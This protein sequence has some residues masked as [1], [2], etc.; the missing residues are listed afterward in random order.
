M[1]EGAVAPDA[2]RI[3]LF[4]QGNIGQLIVEPSSELGFKPMTHEHARRGASLSVEDR[5]RM[6]GAH[7]DCV[8]AV[9]L[10]CNLPVPSGALR[11]H[12]NCPEGRVLDVDFQLFDG[13]DQHVAAV[14]LTPKYGRE[15]ADH[16][17]SPDRASLMEP[18]TVAS[19]AHFAV[20]AVFRLPL[21]D[22]RQAALVDRLLQVGQ[23]DALQFQR[24]LALGHDSS[25]LR[26]ARDDNRASMQHQQRTAIVTGAGKRIGAVIAA[27][28]VADG[29][30]VVAHVHHAEDSVPEGAAKVVAELTDLECAP[31]IFDAAEALPPVRLLVNNAA[32]FAPDSFGEFREAEL[33][34]HM[35]V[36]L[37][38][39]I[40]LSE[41]FSRRHSGDDGLIVNLLD[42]KLAAPNPDFLSYTLSKQALA[43][44][45]DL[46]SR[47][48]ASRGIR[49]NAIA[50]AL[51]LRSSGQSVE[52]F[53]RVHSL[54]PLHRGVEPEDVVSALRYLIS[55]RAVTGETIVIDGGQ[56]FSPPPRDVQFLED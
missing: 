39:P 9:Q 18:G 35:A 12:L 22:R 19:D 5:Q 50:P 37:R 40:L 29:W 45:T 56:R 4:R 43:G 48:L 38:A 53:E 15:E 41:E 7:D 6:L 34:A 24:R 26:R 31:K 32:R 8:S 28:L 52:N 55:A 42:S 2:K 27:E 11:V 21:V 23:T 17:R 20:T 10:Q 3:V 33:D 46:A 14:R 25:L 47:A 1:K 16:C 30:S 13:S 49:V 51:M 44:F 36:N 54:N